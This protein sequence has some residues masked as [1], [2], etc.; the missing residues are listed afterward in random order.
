MSDVFTPLP[1]QTQGAFHGGLAMIYRL[2][3]IHKQ[4]HHHRVNKDYAAWFEW[5]TCMHMELSPLMHRTVNKDLKKSKYLSVDKKK[6]ISQHQYYAEFW[7]D[8]RTAISNIRKNENVS[9]SISVLMA[10]ED[11]LGCFEQTIG[12][13]MPKKLDGRLALGQ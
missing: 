3:S 2:D 8:A 12:A 7:K 11:E 6:S 10:W 1:D 5:L 9:A 13:K 4:I